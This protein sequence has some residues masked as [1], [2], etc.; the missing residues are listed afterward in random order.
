[1]KRYEWV[2]AAALMAGLS[3]C[4][5]RMAHSRAGSR[6]TEGKS[7]GAPPSEASGARRHRVGSV[8]VALPPGWSAPSTPVELRAASVL[9]RSERA[10]G[11]FIEIWD[12]PE[13]EVDSDFGWDVQADA[14]GR[15][16]ARIV[17]SSSCAAGSREQC[18]AEASRA[19]DPELAGLAC[20]E[21]SGGDGRLDI[22]GSFDGERV[23]PG[24]VCFHVGND[25]RE[26][27]DRGELRQIVMTFEVEPR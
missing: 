24:G 4:H 25:E 1:M 18:R 16:V 8:S 5:V 21:C 22:W 11:G 14:S 9:L 7:P 6:L 27:A 2:A 20:E 23:S 17:E 12:C 3:A 15:G 13:T 10:G 26:D 19:A